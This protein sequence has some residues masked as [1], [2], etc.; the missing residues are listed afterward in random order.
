MIRVGL[1]G[2]IAT[3]K[4]SVSEILRIHKIPV[5]DADEVARKVVA[6]GTSGLTAIVAHFG[7]AILRKDGHLARD[8]LRQKVINDSA[9]R[10]QLEAITH[11]RIQATIDCWLREQQEIGFTFAAVEAALLV[12]T[13]SY[14][15]YDFIVVVACDPFIQKSRLMARNQISP[16]EAA[17]WIATQLP[18][19]DKMAVA[20]HVIIND[21]STSE[22]S[23]QVSELI[24]TIKQ[25]A[26]NR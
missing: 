22:L 7:P 20:N 17:A 18:L 5:I 21:G 1:T 4:S 10:K 3:G 12:E 24:S 15:N 23:T 6:P 8:L 2:G 19:Q 25:F 9:A 26:I 16:E 13:G 14:R 11:P